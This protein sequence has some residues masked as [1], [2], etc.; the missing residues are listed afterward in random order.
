MDFGE[1][2]R[3]RGLTSATDASSS[4]ILQTERLF[5]GDRGRGLAPGATLLAV[6]DS[7]TALIRR[8]GGHQPGRRL[9]EVDMW[10]MFVKPDAGSQRSA[11]SVGLV[12]TPES[13][14]SGWVKEEYYRALSLTKKNSL[15]LI[16]LLL[17]D[18]AYPGFLES[19]HHVD[20]RNPTLYDQKVDKLIWP[21]ITGKKVIF[22]SIHGVGGFP[23]PSLKN[24]IS[25][26]EFTVSGT[27]YVE[28][29]L[30]KIP[31]LIAQGYRVVV[32]VDIL[33]DWP[34]SEHRI[35]EPSRYAETV[36]KVRYEHRGC[37]SL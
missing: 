9:G 24:I 32:I 10:V 25:E 12:V 3:R 23:W 29:A 37:S 21:G 26:N 36:I 7:G 28:A 30:Y 14:A 17:K 11:S 5:S 20:F 1:A 18:A 22:L 35:R 33:E 13:V 27:D 19:R 34:W 31:D 4:V 15:Q 8:Y 16:P 2:A 6:C